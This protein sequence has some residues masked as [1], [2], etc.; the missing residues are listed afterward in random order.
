MDGLINS[1]FKLGL[2]AGAVGALLIPKLINRSTRKK[3]VTIP[4]PVVNNFADIEKKENCL[5]I[6]DID[7]TMLTFKGMSTG[8]WKKMFNKNLR[9]TND[10]EYSGSLTIK[11]FIQVIT[12]E[13]PTGTDVEGFWELHRWCEQSNGKV[14]FLTARPEK[15][16]EITENQLKSVYEGLNPEVHFASD[17]G[18]K[19]KELSK[20]WEN[21]VFVDDKIHNLTDVKALNPEVS[22]YQFEPK[23]YLTPLTHSKR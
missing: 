23:K 9:E 4:C 16:R 19:L 6:L 2:A 17:K 8:W 18:N 11:Q 1:G 10:V 7:E 5:Y 12:S 21:I 3:A 15:I 22:C 13:F 14:I 20:D